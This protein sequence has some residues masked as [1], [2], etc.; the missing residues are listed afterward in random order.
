M[1]EGSRLL[2]RVSA[3]AAPLGYR[4]WPPV[5]VLPD[6]ALEFQRIDARNHEIEAPLRRS[7]RIAVD[8]AGVPL[9]SWTVQVVRD[10]P[11]AVSLSEPPSVT[12]RASLRLAYRATDDYGVTALRAELRLAAEAPPALVDDPTLV[13]ALPTPGERGKVAGT[14]YHDLTPHPWAGFPVRL[15]LVAEDGAGQSGRSETVIVTLPERVFEHPVAR[16]IIAERRRLLSY[17]APMH[18]AVGE[19]LSDLST[20]PDHFHQDLVVFLALRVAV[21]RLLSDSASPASL[22]EVPALLWETALR[23]EDGGVTLAER[24]VREAGRRLAEALEQGADVETVRRLMSELQAAMDRYMQALNEQMQRAAENGEP[25]PRLRDGLPMQRVDRSDLDALMQQMQALAETGAYDS[26]RQMLSQ[27]QS[28]LEN[29]QAGP[30]QAPDQGQAWTLLED[31]QDL[32]Q[33][34]ERLLEE[35]FGQGQQ[36]ERDA[37]RQ[38]GEVVPGE[39]GERW[40]PGDSLRTG[41]AQHDLRLELGEVMRRSSELLDEIPEP[42]GQAEQAMRQAERALQLGM[43]QAAVPVQSEALDHLHQGL[44]SF[45]QQLAQR[46]AAFTPGTGGQPQPGR[47]GRDPLGRPMPGSGRLDDSNVDIPEHGTVQRAREILKELRRRAGE[48]ARPPEE[49]D[50]IQRLLEL[51]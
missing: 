20:Q 46:M 18:G 34:Q 30:A 15:T 6:A 21:A 32:A 31:L 43:P 45:A 9:G 12:A 36:M 7:G 44:E 22:A 11:P 48:T 13:L 24:A 23:L 14:S 29:L 41:N 39:P 3:S 16:A 17:G 4:D 40:T 25:V 50:Y 8:R 37:A 47:M 1:P 2:A 26:A 10:Q 51:F 42:L 28:F 5:L 49:R 19:A 35:A 33:Q 27:L 38:R